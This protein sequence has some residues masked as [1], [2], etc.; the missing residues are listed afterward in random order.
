MDS[1]YTLLL[2]IK[3]DFYLDDIT[4]K[5]AKEFRNT[6]QKLPANSTKGRFAGKTT[7]EIL[8]MSGY[9]PMSTSNLNKNIDRMADLVHYAIEKDLV[10]GVK[11]FFRGL[12]VIDPVPESE[13]RRPFTPQEIAQVLTFLLDVLDNKQIL[14]DRRSKLHVDYV[15]IFLLG[16][17]TG[18]R[19]NELCQ[20]TYEDV[21]EFEGI[22]CLIV[23]HEPGQN[24]TTKNLYS[25]RIVPVPPQMIDLGF[26]EF[27]QKRATE[28]NDRLWVSVS[29]DDFGKWNKNFGRNMNQ[30]IDQALGGQDKSICLHSTRHNLGNALDDCEV[31]LKTIQ[32]IKGH[33]G[34]STEERTYLK[35]KFHQQLEALRLL[36]YGL[37]MDAI[38]ERMAKHMP[39]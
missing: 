21:L 31:K 12:T 39:S 13:K 37:D 1:S 15:W 29:L 8:E 16:L 14:N 36:N 5:F 23:Q 18:F 10:T 25:R 32:D 28:G 20:L 7:Q 3:G 9:L 4:Y 27:A 26:L 17:Y 6:L 38:K 30:Y 34:K 19:S 24:K 11:N 33:A 35:K 22:H 2:R